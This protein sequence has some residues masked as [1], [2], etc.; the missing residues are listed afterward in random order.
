MIKK[1]QM[2]WNRWTVQ[3]FLDLRVAVLDGTLEGSFRRVYPE[4][5]PANDCGPTSAA[6]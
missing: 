1:Q 3:P 5:R 2:R 6:A 4:F